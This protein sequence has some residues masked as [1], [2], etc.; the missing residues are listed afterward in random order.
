MMQLRQSLEGLEP[1]FHSSRTTSPTPRSLIKALRNLS[2]NRRKKV[3]TLLLFIISCCGTPKV[4]LTS[5]RN[6]VANRSHFQKDDDFVFPPARMRNYRDKD[7]K[8]TTRNEIR[9]RVQDLSINYYLVSL[10]G[11]GTLT[12]EP[13]RDFDFR[14]SAI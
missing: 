6:F 5:T 8:E 3:E 1:A 9:D 4:I 10:N 2:N 11:A 14:V 13:S 12:S 7:L